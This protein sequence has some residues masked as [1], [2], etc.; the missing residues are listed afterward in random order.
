MKKLGTQYLLSD[1]EFLPHWG[2]GLYALLFSLALSIALVLVPERDPSEHSQPSTGITQHALPPEERRLED[3]PVRVLIRLEQAEKHELNPHLR[4]DIRIA[5][6]TALYAHRG[7]PQPAIDATYRV[8][9][10]HPDKVWPAIVAR[11]KA[12]LGSAYACVYDATGNLQPG[13]WQQWVID[14]TPSSPKK[15]VRSVRVVPQKR[16]GGEAA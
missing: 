7:N 4:D 11:R 12:M 3:F 14:G 8:L 6:I 16:E 13:G 1:V 15:P 9:G 10:I 5:W 2:Q